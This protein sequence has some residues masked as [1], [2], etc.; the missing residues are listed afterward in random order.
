MHAELVANLLNISRTSA[1]PGKR[2]WC[3]TF[4]EN[5]K[6]VGSPV[7]GDRERGMRMLRT[8]VDLCE[9]LF[10]KASG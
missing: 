6:L 10:V 1:D 3:R 8:N 9:R 2:G 4:A 5:L 7:A